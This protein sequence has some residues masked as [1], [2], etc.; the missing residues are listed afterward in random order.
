MRRNQLLAT[1]ILAA[2]A[3]VATACA[4]EPPPVSDK[5]AQYYSNPPTPE[6]KKVEPVV[7]FI[8]DSYVAGSSQDTGQQFPDL[9]AAKNGWYQLDL[10]EGG[11][12]YVTKGGKG[13]TFAARVP[14]AIDS[15]ASLIVVS[16]GFNDKETLALPDAVTGV[17]N[18]LH[19]GKPTVPIV[20]LS[21]F[22]PSGNPTAS[23]LEKRD[24]IAASAAA[25]GS[26]FIDVT[27]VFAGR[28]DLIGADKVH[29]NA[30]GHQ[31]IADYL[32]TRLPAPKA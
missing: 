23:Q 29:P 6:P 11:S 9:I 25:T 4:A 22:V 32:V 15:D 27:E 30:T 24:I 16:G 8:G 3:A 1:A 5:V 20:V 28:P 14:R 21:N 19:A 2:T 13:T 10:G 31:F 26:T 18:Q 17:L 7:A 12:G